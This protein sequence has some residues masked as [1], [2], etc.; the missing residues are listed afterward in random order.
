MLRVSALVALLAVA[1]LGC[2]QDMHDQPKYKPYRQSEFFT[3]GRAMRPFVAGTVAQGTLRDDT[4]LFAGKSGGDFVTEIPLAVTADLLERG[5]SEF[6]V[7]CSPCHGRT[8]MGDGMIVRRGFKRPTSY[9]VDR[10]R[11]TPVGYFFDVIT[12]G[13]GAMSDY[14]AQVPV[15]DRWAIVAYVRTL[16]LSQY[17]PAADVPADRKAELEA[18]LQALDAHEDVGE[19]H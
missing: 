6:R 17:A 15:E 9:H 16:Q 18:S 2:R 10:L 12:N 7:F 14:A 4:A 3:D 19:G 11:Q 13:Y 1:G 8:G 5:R